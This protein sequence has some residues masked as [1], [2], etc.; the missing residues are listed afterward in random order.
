MPGQP[1]GHRSRPAQNH[2]LRVQFPTGF[3]TDRAV[4]DGHFDR[5]QRTRLEPV[6]IQGWAERPAPT[7]AQRVFAAVQEEST[8]LL[9]AT[10][11]LPEYEQVRGDS[12]STLALTLLRSVG[13]LSRD[14]LDC[15]PGH[16]GPGYATPGA[17][18]LGPAR[19][20]SA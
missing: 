16:A 9:I 11:G 18:C 5:L 8:G 14:D 19:Y 3:Q 10:R 13:W 15:R 12:G 7:A 4:V 1:R 17:Q 20:D 2:R 6:D